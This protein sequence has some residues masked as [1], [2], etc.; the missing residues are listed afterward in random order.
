MGQDSVQLRL[1]ELKVARDS[2]EAQKVLGALS[3]L[4]GQDEVGAALSQQERT[5]AKALCVSRGQEH[6]AKNR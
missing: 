3:D 1:D 6:G 2:A 5:Q 4:R